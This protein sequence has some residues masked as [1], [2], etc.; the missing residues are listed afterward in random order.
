MVYAWDKIDPD[1]NIKGKTA[2]VSSTMGKASSK[3]SYNQDQLKYLTYQVIK[4]L[5]LIHDVGFVHCS[6]SPE[7]IRCL[8]EQQQVCLAG[9]LPSSSDHSPVSPRY[10]IY[11]CIE[12]LAG[13]PPHPSWDMHSLAYSLIV[14][15]GGIL[16][17]M[18]YEDKSEILS[19]RTARTDTD[20]VVCASTNL[21]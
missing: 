6:V 19:H 8:T 16:P 2:V 10:P 9:Y 11:C 15:A 21:T 13:M 4:A 5:Q 3:F 14:L 18:E 7:T 12:E 17:W 20:R 1:S